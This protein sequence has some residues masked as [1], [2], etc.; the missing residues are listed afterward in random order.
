MKLLLNAQRN[1]QLFSSFDF[2]ELAYFDVM[3]KEVQVCRH[4]WLDVCEA[5]V[6]DR[7]KTK[8]S[9]IQYNY[10]AVLTGEADP[11]V[12]LVTS[13]QTMQ[14]MDVLVCYFGARGEVCD[15]QHKAH[16]ALKT[17]EL[18]THT[19][20]RRHSCITVAI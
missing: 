7:Q 11:I 8:E 17:A 3:D 20:Y 15:L 16:F 14:Y 10:S 13:G 1:Q 19:I 9:L 18:Y 12:N 6:K 2:R 4:H 5:A